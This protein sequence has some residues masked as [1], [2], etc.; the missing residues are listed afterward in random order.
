MPTAQATLFSPFTFAFNKGSMRYSVVLFLLF[1]AGCQKENTTI[2]LKAGDTMDLPYETVAKMPK[3]MELHWRL[4]KDGRCPEKALCP[5]VGSVILDFDLSKGNTTRSF[6]LE[7]HPGDLS[8]SIELEGYRIE[9]VD[10]FPPLVDYL[11]EEDYVA[12]VKLSEL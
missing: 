3:G 5:W 10:V 2:R 9:L 6:Q 4:N 7:T 11:E 8:Q 12:R 1:L